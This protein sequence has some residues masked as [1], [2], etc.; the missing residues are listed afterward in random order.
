MPFKVIVA[1]NFHYMDE[2]E[3]YEYGTF[4]SLELAIEA[5]KR[6]VDEYLA[7]AYN[8]SMS[9]AQLYH[10]FVSFGEDPYIVAEEGTGVLFSAWDYARERCAVL[11]PPDNDSAGNAER[12]A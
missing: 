5:A 7:S 11:C 10:S 4:D 3:S 8:S 9:A 2:S 1:D 6:I 12:D